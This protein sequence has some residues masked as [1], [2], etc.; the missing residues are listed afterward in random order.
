MSLSSSCRAHLC[1]CLVA[2]DTCARPC[3]NASVF[4]ILAGILLTAVLHLATTTTTTITTTT[5]TKMTTITAHLTPGR[6][7]KRY[8]LGQCSTLVPYPTAPDSPHKAAKVRTSHNSHSTPST[9]TPL[10]APPLPQPPQHGSR[11]TTPRHHDTNAPPYQRNTS[12]TPLFVPPIYC[13]PVWPS[14]VLACPRMSPQVT[15]DA[16][17]TATTFNV[18]IYTS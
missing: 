12:L 8:T 18:A 17:I 5:T 3:A 1:F 11:T 7:K 9:P 15:S 10:A 4:C 16:G 6:Q 14:R 13:P 2:P